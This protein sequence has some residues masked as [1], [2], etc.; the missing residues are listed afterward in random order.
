MIKKISHILQTLVVY[1]PVHNTS[2]YLDA[3]VYTMN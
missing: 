3:T 1:Y 2:L